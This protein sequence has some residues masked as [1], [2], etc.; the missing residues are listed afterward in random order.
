MVSDGAMKKLESYDYPGNIREL[1]NIIMQSVSMAESEHVL[2]EKILQMP[3]QSRHMTGRLESWN[4]NEPLYEYLEAIEKELIREAI[5]RQG[6]NITKAA[7]D[8]K[9]KRQTLQHKLKKYDMLN[10]K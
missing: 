6:G 4:E 3:D 2:T 7:D 5:I 1:E 10:S 9:I 8:L